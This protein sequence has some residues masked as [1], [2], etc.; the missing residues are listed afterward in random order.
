MKQ[1]LHA[2][3]PAQTYSSSDVDVDAFGIRTASKCVLNIFLFRLFFFLSLSCLE[4]S[5]VIKVKSNGNENARG[6]SIAMRTQTRH[7]T[8]VQRTTNNEQ[9]GKNSYQLRV[10][11]IFF[12]LTG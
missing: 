8:Y 9:M 2:Q 12:M 11:C 6:S 10:Q 3:A 1:R 5:V 4:Q 7:T